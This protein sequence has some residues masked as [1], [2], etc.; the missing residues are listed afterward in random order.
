[1]TCERYGKDTDTCLGYGK[2]VEG[3][4]HVRDLEWILRACEG[5]GKDFKGM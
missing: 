5:F 3:M 1:M 2:V 4:W